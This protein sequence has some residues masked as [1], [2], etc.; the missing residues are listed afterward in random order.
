MPSVY[1]K[2]PARRKKEV[3]DKILQGKDFK[4]ERIVSRG[5]ATPEGKWYDQKDDEWVIL[6]KG[7]AGLRIKGKRQPITLSPGDYLHL[8]AH[9]RHR[10]EWTQKNT[11]TVWLALH[12]QHRTK[13]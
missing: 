3:F 6:L 8:P 13:A 11:Q 7:R 4:L 5:H 12:Y 1:S 10:V 9:R 2:I